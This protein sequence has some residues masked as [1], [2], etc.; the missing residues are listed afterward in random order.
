[1]E[2]KMHL[3]L[4]AYKYEGLNQSD[5]LVIA[6]LWKVNEAQKKGKRETWANWNGIS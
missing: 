6:S 3:S 1:M 5:I 4:T 2:R